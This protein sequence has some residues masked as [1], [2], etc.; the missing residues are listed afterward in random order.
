MQAGGVQGHSHTPL[1]PDARVKHQVREA[2]S[3]L[4]P[5][6]RGGQSATLGMQQLMLCVSCEVVLWGGP[7]ALRAKHDPKAMSASPIMEG[8]G[9]DEC[10]LVFVRAPE[11][12]RQACPEQTL[13]LGVGGRAQLFQQ[14]RALC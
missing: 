12:A 8:A 6:Q 3:Q 13:R 7:G 11:S 2:F 5:G 4:L 9:V 1:R 10:G 14:L